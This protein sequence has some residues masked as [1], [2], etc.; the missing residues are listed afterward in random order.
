MLQLP[1]DE[2]LL[3]GLLVLLYSKTSKI[4]CGCQKLHVIHTFHLLPMYVKR[5]VLNSPGPPII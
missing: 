4:K 5:I 3:L 2:E 1:E